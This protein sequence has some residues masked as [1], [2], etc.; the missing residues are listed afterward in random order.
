MPPVNVIFAAGPRGR[1]PSASHRG[2][3]RRWD[4]HGSGHTRGLSRIAEL[5][6]YL[7]RLCWLCARPF[8]PLAQAGPLAAATEALPLSAA[9]VSL[10]HTDFL[11]TVPRPPPPPLT[12]ATPMRET[13]EGFALERPVLQIQNQYEPPNGKH[14]LLMYAAMVANNELLMAGSDESQVRSPQHRSPQH[15]RV[16]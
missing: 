5:L 6:F 1:S 2:G 15:D 7:C 10:I 12:A 9:G 13:A 3:R 8:W 4:C 16:R 11:L 14:Q